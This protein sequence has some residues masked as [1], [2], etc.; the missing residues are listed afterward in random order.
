MK[1][2][3]TEPKNRLR[4]IG[5]EAEQVVATYMH[6]R[7]EDDVRASY[8]VYVAKCR[9]A[10]EKARSISGALDDIEQ[11]VGSLQNASE[12]KAELDDIK[13]QADSIPV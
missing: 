7:W 1:V 3:F 8:N 13:A 10:P 11:L 5:Q 9:E 4:T 2:D 12:V 6:A